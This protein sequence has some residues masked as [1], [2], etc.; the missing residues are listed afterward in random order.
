MSSGSSPATAKRVEPG[1][2]PQ[3]AAATPSRS[4]MISAADAPS[5][6]GDELPGGDAASAISGNRADF[7]GPRTTTSARTVP[8]RWCAAR[9]VS[10]AVCVTVSP[11][12]LVTE[13]G[14]SPCR[15]SPST[16]ASAARWCDCAENASRVSAVELPLGGDQFGG[17]ALV[18]QP[19]GVAGGDARAGRRPDR[20][21]SCPS[22]RGTSTPHR[23]RSRCRRRRRSRPARRSAPPAGSSRTGGRRWWPEPNPGIRAAAPPSGRC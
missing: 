22:E 7:S 3:P 21:W 19:L 13:T 6:S 11:A 1:P 12:A 14:R 5:V 20:W 8:R 15:T 2:G 23:R 17:D 4:L 10:S 9:T 16:A 18:D